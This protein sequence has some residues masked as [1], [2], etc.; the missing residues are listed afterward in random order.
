[1]GLLSYRL[2][3]FPLSHEGMGTMMGSCRAGWSVVGGENQK[4]DLTS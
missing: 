3:L 2:V 1:M 4:R